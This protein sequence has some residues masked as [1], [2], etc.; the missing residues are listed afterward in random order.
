MPAPA[1]M[2]SRKTKDN[3]IE[4]NLNIASDNIA[5]I[6]RR[7]GNSDLFFILTLTFSRDNSPFHG[8]TAISMMRRQPL[9]FG[10]IFIQV[11]KN[12]LC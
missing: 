8:F 1:S 9:Y 10:A 3:V 2:H 5:E 6:G 11:N 7:Y 12:G 4:I